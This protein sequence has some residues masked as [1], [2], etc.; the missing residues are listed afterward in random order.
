MLCGRRASGRFKGIP[1]CYLLLPHTFSFP[2]S[3]SLLRGWHGANSGDH[4]HKQQ[5]YQQSTTDGH[6]SRHI[7]I[8]SQMTSLLTTHRIPD[9]FHMNIT[10]NRLFQK[11][12]FLR[13]RNIIPAKT[14]EIDTAGNFTAG[15]TSAVPF[16]SMISQRERTILQQP[17]PLS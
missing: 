11:N 2:L 6:F 12:H 15:I 16:D 3:D 5:G 13:Q 1:R 10:V 7:K 4:C 14:I 17:H 9:L 8:L